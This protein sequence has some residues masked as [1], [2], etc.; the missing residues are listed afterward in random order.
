MNVN[1]RTEAEVECEMKR[2]INDVITTY[3]QSGMNGLVEKTEEYY[4]KAININQRWYCVYFDVACH[5]IDISIVDSVN[6]HGGKLAYNNYYSDALMSNRCTPVYTAANFPVDKAIE[7][8]NA[9]I[10]MIIEILE[11]HLAR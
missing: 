6:R 5:V 9:M 11:K 8:R 4:A 10:L 7:H 1:A 3:Q 2:A